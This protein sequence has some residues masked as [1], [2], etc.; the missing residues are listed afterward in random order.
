MGTLQHTLLTLTTAYS[1]PLLP[2]ETQ[3]VVTT[4]VQVRVKRTLGSAVRRDDGVQREV[5]RGML[6][7]EWERCGEFVK[8]GKWAGAR[9]CLKG[10]TGMVG[11]MGK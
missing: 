1:H 3:Y 10:M 9:E 2:S 5:L 4:P 7:T 6:V 11:F 8:M